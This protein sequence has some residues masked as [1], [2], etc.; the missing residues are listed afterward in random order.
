MSRRE[1]LTLLAAGTAAL[2]LPA[3]VKAAA[4]TSPGIVKP[5][6]DEWFTL[7]GTNA[8]T[9]WEA[10]R[11]TG[12]LTPADHF[13][14]RNHTSTPVVDAATWRLKVWGSALRGGPGLDDA[15]EFGLDDLRA[16][17]PVEHTAF[18]ECA[19]NGR[20]FYASQQGQ[21]VSG[22]AWTLG[23]VGVARWRGARLSDVLRRAGVTRHAVDVMPRG[24]DDEYVTG[25]VSLGRVRRPLPVAKALD[26]VIL[27][28]D[29]NGAPLPHD[30]GRPVRVLVPSWVGISSVKWVGDIEVSAE[31]LYSPW[32]TDF[33]RLFGPGF[34]EAGSAPLTRQSLKS[35]F[36]LE[37]GAAFP[38][39]VRSIL[40]GRSWSGAGECGRWRSAPTAV[41]PGGGPDCA[42]S[43]AGTG[44]CAGP[45]RGGRARRARPCCWRAPPTP[46]GGPSRTRRC[47]TPRA[48]SS[49]P[50]C[51]IRWSSPDAT[52][53]VGTGRAAPCTMRTTE[54]TGR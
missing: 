4:A 39:G 17:P 43:R 10:L 7:R 44:G 12:Y 51:G 40:H 29:M 11:G 27:A 52:S 13:F 45:S 54:V 50:W 3:P 49:T 1:V 53:W 16:L 47:S 18:V 24:L 15:V 30:H 20:S 36:E 9:K 8:E 38:A 23:A 25:G 46:R 19:G 33:Y 5:L 32:N 31:P 14:V 28:Y 34:P 35:A 48:T 26:D 42:T 21:T 6:P 22:T 2:A 37:A 41:P